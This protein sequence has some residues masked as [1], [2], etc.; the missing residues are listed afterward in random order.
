MK[1]LELSKVHLPFEDLLLNDDEMFVIKGGSVSSADSG[2]GCDCGCECSEGVGCGCECSEGVGCG[3]DCV[4]GAG[5]G[6]G[7]K[8]TPTPAPKKK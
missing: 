6:C 2:S 8:V 1:T 4:G 7:C 5:C 3:C